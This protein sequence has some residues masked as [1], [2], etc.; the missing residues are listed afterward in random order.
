MFGK[1]RKIKCAACG[2]VWCKCGEGKPSLMANGEDYYVIIDGI[3]GFCVLRVP[4]GSE[5]EAV[6]RAVLQLA[7]RR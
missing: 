1:T 6:K 4:P 3:P 5:I 2:Y 7:P